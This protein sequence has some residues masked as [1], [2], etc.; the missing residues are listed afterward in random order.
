MD[1]LFQPLDLAGQDDYRAF[2]ARC[3]Q[4][5][6]DHTF[7]N[8]WTWRNIYGIEWAW[9]K[10]LVW[11]RQ[12]KPEPLLWAPV[13]D[14]EGPDWITYFSKWSG[15]TRMT[16]I[17]QT[18]AEIWQ[19]QLGSR[20][21]LKDARDHWE[22]VYSVPELIELKGN[23]F[24]K[25][26][27]LL[28]Q[29]QRANTFSFVPLEGDFV[30]QARQLQADWCQWRDC[31]NIET[32]QE[33]NQAIEQVF[34]HWDS[35]VGIMGAGLLVNGAMVGYTVAEALDDTTLVIHFEKAC[36]EIKGAYQTINQMF[37]ERMGSQFQT[38]NREQDLGDEGLRKAKLSY[39]PMVFLQKSFVEL[40]ESESSGHP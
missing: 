14:W 16:R 25:K 9:E 40:E 20:I 22:Y 17:P 7:V 18:L 31:E 24:H 5:T 12:T 19:A 30:D 4:R 13:G 28:N 6:A 11:I 39:N 33:E 38:V 21:R 10:D 26:K 2:F 27:N 23:K 37:L 15:T 29:F 32:L 3:A 34:S 36:S 35:L 1:L 8:L